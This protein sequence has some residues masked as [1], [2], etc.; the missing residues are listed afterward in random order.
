[1]TSSEADRHAFDAIAREIGMLPQEARVRFRIANGL[2]PSLRGALRGSALADDVDSLL[3]LCRLT[4][5]QQVKLYHH[6]QGGLFAELLELAVA[7]AADG[8]LAD[9]LDRG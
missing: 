9:M 8:T 3:M 1:M 5:D 7:R 4:N 2:H 6:L